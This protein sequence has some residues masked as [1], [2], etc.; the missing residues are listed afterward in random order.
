MEEHYTRSWSAGCETPGAEMSDQQQEESSYEL[1]QPVGG[2]WPLSSVDL[3]E[4]PLGSRAT[5]DDLLCAGDLDG[6]SEGGS[7]RRSRVSQNHRFSE[8]RTS[9]D[10]FATTDK[11]LLLKTLIAAESAAT[12][13]AVQ[14]VSFRDILEEDFSDSRCSSELRLSRQKGLLLEK[15]EVFKRINASV[16]QQLKE[17]LEEEMCRTETDKH[18]DALLKKLALTERENQDLRLS[19]SDRERKVEELMALRK[20]EM[21]NTESVVQLSRSVD[22]TRAHLQLQLR[23]KEAENNRLMVQL[24]ALERTVAQ[25][26][27]ELEDLRAQMDSVSAAASEEKEALKKATR[28]QKLR[29]ERFESAVEKLYDQLR[30]KDVK[31]AEVRSERDRWRCEQETATEE[32]VRLDAEITSLKEEISVLNAELQRERQSVKAASDLLLEKVE[33]LNS[34]NA[35]LTL[36]NST[37]KATVAELEE[38]LQE[39]HAAF[40]DQTALTEERKHQVEEYQSQIA[41]LQVEVT[42]LK[43]KLESQLQETRELREGRDEEVAQVRQCLEMRVRQLESYPELLQAAEQNLQLSQEQ[44]QRYENTISNKTE[45]IR[46]LNIQVDGHAEKLK[47]SLEMKDSIKEANAQLQQ[48][49]DSLQKKVEEVQSENQELISRLSS[50]EGALQYSSRQLEQR[51][52]ECQALRRQLES[53]LTDVAQQVCKVKEKASSRE[54]TLQ[55]RILEL[56]AEKNRRENELK[57]LRLSKVSSEKQFEMRLKDLQLSLD[58]SESHKQSIQNYVDFLKNSYATMFE[59][60]LPSTYGSSYYLK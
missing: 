9:Y 26:K 3:R 13:A 37:L 34:D 22:T 43:I 4:S 10:N 12:S 16:R 14:L 11:K 6:T 53:A 52:A 30:E 55:T 1:F 47:S 56:E 40:R 25:Q 50:Q 21:E 8:D 33:K 5:R 58:Q 19:L 24:R 38:K 46:Q 32:R 35:E 57:Q 2:M 39:S 17:F 7:G 31:L 23:N 59:D 60:T 51:S 48:K 45:T 42:E 28:A 36:Q 27:L 20:K 15:L 18:I 54:N 41:E 29:A 49:V 44:L